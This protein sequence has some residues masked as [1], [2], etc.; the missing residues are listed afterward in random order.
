MLLTGEPVS[1]ADAE[2]MG[3]VSE[4]VAD[5]QAL[6]RALEI[7]TSI[8]RLP[9]IAAREIK[10]LVLS[11]VDQSLEDGLIDERRTF[12]SMF[13]T[14]DQK[15]GMRAFIEKRRPDFKGR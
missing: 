6:P 14:E 10:R 7:A 15:E 3:L 13:D 2:A 4:V 5:E 12:V 8:A 1:A 9:P 11:G